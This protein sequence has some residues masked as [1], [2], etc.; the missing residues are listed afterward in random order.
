MIRI[1]SEFTPFTI[2]RSHDENLWGP[3]FSDRSYVVETRIEAY[4]VDAVGLRMA[5]ALVPEVDVETHSGLEAYVNDFLNLLY[6][7]NYSVIVEFKQGLPL[8]SLLCGGDVKI[9]DKYEFPYDLLNF[10]V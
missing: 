7:R 6:D 3:S 4:M 10:L 9:F 8:Y 2:S 5:L 1:A